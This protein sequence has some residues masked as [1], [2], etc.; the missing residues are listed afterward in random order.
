M[1]SEVIPKFDEEFWLG[2][3]KKRKNS[4]MDPDPEESA[5]SDYDF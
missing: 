4:I 1:D 3:R 5:K 2:I